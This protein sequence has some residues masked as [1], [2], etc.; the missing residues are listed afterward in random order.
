MDSCNRSKRCYKMNKAEIEVQYNFV[1]Y[2]YVAENGKTNPC[3][4]IN[5]SGIMQML[6]K[7]SALVRYKTHQYIEALEDRLKQD[8]YIK[9]VSKGQDFFWNVLKIF[10]IYFETIK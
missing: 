7:E 9:N 10:C 4:K 8:P 1:P 6:N 3:Y 5:K 2:S